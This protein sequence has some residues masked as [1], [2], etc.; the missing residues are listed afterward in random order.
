MLL[1]SSPAYRDGARKAH[2]QK[3]LVQ[4][5]S[6]EIQSF[7]MVQSAFKDPHFLTHF[8]L[9]RL[10]LIDVDAFKDGFGA[11]AYHLQKSDIAKS[12][13]IEPIVFLSKTLSPAKKRYWPTELE[14]AAMVWVVRKLHHMIRAS[15]QKT[16]IWTD[17]SATSSIVNQTNLFTFNIDKLNLRLVRAAMYLSQFELDIRH[18]ADRD[19]V[20]LD[21]LFRLSF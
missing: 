19:H 15:K 7:N 10:F 4:S 12:T 20:I 11:F 5:S 8:N 17:Y 21:A 13:L 6:R 9:D 16:I 14:V 3:T 18:K 2:T 1:K